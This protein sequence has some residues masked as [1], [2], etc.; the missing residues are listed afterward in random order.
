MKGEAGDDTLQGK[1]GDDTL[2]GGAGKNTLDGGLGDDTYIIT[3]STDTIK[4]AGGFDVVQSYVDIELAEGIE[5]A[6]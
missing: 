3:S 4:D 5:E 6:T 2:V 1:D